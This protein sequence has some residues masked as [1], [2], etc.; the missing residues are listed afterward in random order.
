MK[1]KIKVFYLILND[2][3]RLLEKKDRFKFFYFLFFS[4]LNTLLEIISLFLLIN[5]LFIIAEINTGTSKIFEMVYWLINRSPI[6][7]S[8]ILM[9]SV[10]IFKFIFQTIYSYEQERFGYN[11]QRKISQKV[12]NTILNIEYLEYLKLNSSNVT[13]MLNS[14]LIRINNQL[15]SPIVSILNELLLIASICFLIFTYNFLLGISILLFSI[16]IIFVFIL[17]INNKLKFYSKES[18]LYS[19]KMIKHILESHKA[20][21][22]INLFGVKSSFVEKFEAIIDR[23]VKYGHKTIFLLRLPKNLFELIIFLFISI[24]IFILYFL[25]KTELIVEYIGIL[26]V[27][28]FKLIPSLN[29]LSGSIQAIQYFSKPFTE[30]LIF[31]KLKNIQIDSFKK[32]ENFQKIKYNNLS[33]SYDGQTNVLDENNL[34]IFKNDF[35]GIVGESGSGKSTL[36]N[37]ISGLI[38]SKNIEVN[39]DDCLIQGH[40]LRSLCSIVQQ[41]TVILDQTIYV[42][43]ALEFDSNK[44]D[45]HSINNLLKQV[46]LYHTLKDKLDQSLGENGNKLSGGQKQRIGIARA[47]FFNKKIL[48]LDESTS[49]LDLMNQKGIIDLLYNLKRKITII[50][51]SHNKENLINCDKI[52]EVSQGKIITLK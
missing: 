2:F 4:V 27:A 26:S 43:I 23:Y 10:V 35:I 51:I 25:N 33:F 6:L 9:L 31:L 41:E 17:S 47:L 20:Y 46:N 37:L 22:T 28:T 14:D 12:Y 21:L 36:I 40:E 8:T 5:L 30:I 50:F 48:I 49:S 16:T 11:V 42:N 29:K 7:Y 18:I 15:I 19:T 44:I 3:I 45:K 52:L 34:E 13:R 39:L 1:N 24:L 38:Y 32:I